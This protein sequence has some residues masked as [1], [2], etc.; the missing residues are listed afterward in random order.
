M[1]LKGDADGRT[2]GHTHL[3]THLH[4]RPLLSDSGYSP[5]PLYRPNRF[6]GAHNRRAAHT[7]PARSPL[8]KGQ[9]AHNAVPPYQATPRV[10]GSTGSA[11][12]HLLVRPRSQ[13]SLLPD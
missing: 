12:D 13:Q 9:E 5:D 10:Q 11:T 7:A 6:A 1:G 3:H 4:T 2:Q 8:E